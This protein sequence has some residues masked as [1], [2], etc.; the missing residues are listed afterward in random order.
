[1]PNNPYLTRLDQTLEEKLGELI[2]QIKGTHQPQAKVPAIPVLLKIA[3]KNE[4]ETTLLSSHWVCDEEDASFRVSL[5]R[6]AGDEAKHFNLIE[7]EFEKRSG[8]IT[9]EELNQRS[10]LFHFLIKQKNSF[11]RMV[12]GPF[13]RE[14]LAVK[15]NEVFLEYCKENDEQDI[16]NLYEEI[17]RD[18]AHHHQLGRTYLQQ[19]LK[20]EEDYRRA[21]HKMLE[22]LKIVDDIQEI[23]VIKNGMCR[24]P[25]C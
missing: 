12:C 21:E 20:N 1:M 9:A 8:N 18:E 13:T 19:F 15:R 10:P 11:D 17:Q 5:A 16:V 25:G 2:Q 7:K 3:L 6:L 24:L 23:A 4:W 22:T 14:A